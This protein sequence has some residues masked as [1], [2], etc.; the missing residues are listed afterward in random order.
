MLVII[1]TSRVNHYFPSLS[2]TFTAVKQEKFMS[3]WVV[4]SLFK[5]QCH[6]TYQYSYVVNTLNFL[7]FTQKSFQ[8][9]TTEPC[10]CQQSLST[11]TYSGMKIFNSKKL[12]SLRIFYIY[13]FYISM[14]FFPIF[15]VKKK[16]LGQF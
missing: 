4:T 8:H 10:F 2:A 1:G 11:K 16:C 12:I 15:P 14:S 5:G 9:L 13:I 6:L 7:T 3:S